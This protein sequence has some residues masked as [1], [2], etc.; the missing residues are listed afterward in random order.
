MS[1]MS[2]ISAS[3][4]VTNFRR[5]SS[6]QPIAAHFH[7]PMP[8]PPPFNAHT[9]KQRDEGLS[10]Q[11]AQTETCHESTTCGL[12]WKIF[13]SKLEYRLLPDVIMITKHG[14]WVWKTCIW[15]RIIVWLASTT[16]MT[17]PIRV[18]DP[19]I[20]MS[21]MSTEVHRSVMKPQL[22]FPERFFI[23]RQPFIVH[24]RWC[25]TPRSRSWLCWMKH[26][27]T[28]ARACRVGTGVGWRPSQWRSCVVIARSPL[29]EFGPSTH[30]C[31]ADAHMYDKLPEFI[32]PEETADDK[33]RSWKL[34]LSLNLHGH[35]QI[36]TVS[37]HLMSF[38][39]LC[40][41]LTS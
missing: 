2:T 37:S 41:G 23:G 8:L 30:Q 6:S 31:D 24:A 12:N 5:A 4:V 1:T 18:S 29:V 27:E 3:T 34:L 10:K 16:T 20:L 14:L 17:T 21:G 11:D 36:D 32:D 33:H 25:R 39:Q 40:W 7:Q 9:E 22:D 15:E 35:H 28:S 19:L 13:W 26:G 38:R